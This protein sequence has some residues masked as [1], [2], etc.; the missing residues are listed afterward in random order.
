MVFGVCACVV[1]LPAEPGVGSGL[2]FLRQIFSAQCDKT[3]HKPA[4]LPSIG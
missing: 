1:Q 4:A 2:K 3:C